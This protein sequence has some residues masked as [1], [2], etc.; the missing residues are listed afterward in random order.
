MISKLIS[1]RTQKK[2]L[3]SDICYFAKLKFSEIQGSE[4]YHN[5]FKTLKSLIYMD[6]VAAMHL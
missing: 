4:S 2:S 1:N 6:R 5:S 3:I